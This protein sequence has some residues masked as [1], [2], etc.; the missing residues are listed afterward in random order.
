MN[1]ND[2]EVI[3][4]CL[5]S[6]CAYLHNQTALTEY[7]IISH[8][9]FEMAES[10]LEKG[11]RRFGKMFFRPNCTNCSKC[12]PL[13]VDLNNFKPS[14]SMRKSIHKNKEIHVEFG[15]P[16]CTKEH[17][18]LHNIYHEYQNK[19]K[20]WPYHEISATEYRMLFCEPMI[21][22]KEVRYFNK[23]H[24]LIGVGYID[25]LPS[26]YSSLY[27]FYHPE[28]SR[29]SPGVF[30]IMTE[31]NQAIKNNVNSY[32]L[33]YFVEGCPSMNYK[34]KFTP[35]SLF[36]GEDELWSWEDASWR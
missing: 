15:Q 27:F 20:N 35:H 10:Y 31:I 9:T 1:Y 11:W 26:A 24:K 30:S 36:Q 7:N 19:K 4:D 18:T 21:F 2:I 14:R 25:T 12:I 16:E 32:H 33:G 23:A 17:I 6:E 8:P 3:T 22:A 28:W 13:K 29:L 5:K 34:L